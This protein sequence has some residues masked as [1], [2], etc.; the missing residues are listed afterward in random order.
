MDILGLEVSD[1]QMEDILKYYSG[2]SGVGGASTV[3][4][5][6]LIQQSMRTIH[7]PSYVG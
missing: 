3:A 6:I 2:D 7:Y 4:T 1:V 5:I